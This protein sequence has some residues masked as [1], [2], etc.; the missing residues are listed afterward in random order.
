MKTIIVAAL[1]VVAAL[2]IAAA[3]AVAFGWATTPPICAKDSTKVA[4]PTWYRDG[5]YCTA[6]FSAGP[7]SGTKPLPLPTP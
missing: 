1:V 2:S 7:S 4:H 3:P 5:G 6:P